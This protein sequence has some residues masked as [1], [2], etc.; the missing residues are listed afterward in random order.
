MNFGGEAEYVS[1]G[2]LGTQSHT[3]N[4]RTI[5]PI[6]KESNTTVNRKISDL[7]SGQD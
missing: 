5:S 7:T 3:S 6:F 1:K 2:I 4:N